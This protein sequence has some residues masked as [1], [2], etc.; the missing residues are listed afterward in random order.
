MQICL[1][2]KLRVLKVLNKPVMVTPQRVESRLKRLKIA[3]N[4]VWQNGVK[5]QKTSKN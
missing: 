3:L 2:S 4:E 5:R 1:S